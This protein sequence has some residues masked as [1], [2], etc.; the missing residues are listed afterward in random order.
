MRGAAMLRMIR[1]RVAVGAMLIGLLLSGCIFHGG[2]AVNSASAVVRTSIMPASVPYY[3]DPCGQEETEA[4]YRLYPPAALARWLDGKEKSEAETAPEADLRSKH[5]TCAARKRIDNGDPITVR[6]NRVGI[7]GLAKFERTGRGKCLKGCERDIAVVLDFNGGSEIR[8]PIVAF[9][10]T[11][12]QPDGNLQFTNQ[13]IFTQDEWF[14][15]YPPNIR[16]RLYDVRDDRD[17]SLRANLETV[18]RGVNVVTAYIGGA[19]TAGPIVDTAFKAADQLL[20][21]PRN[22]AILDMSFQLFPQASDGGLKAGDPGRP[23]CEV[24][25]GDRDVTGTVLTTEQV[26]AQQSQCQKDKN[27]IASQLNDKKAN[28]KRF[29]TENKLNPSR[30]NEGI[31]GP[32]TKTRIREVVGIGPFDEILKRFY[33]Q[34]DLKEYQNSVVKA[35]DATFE[36]PIYASQYVVFNENAYGLRQITGGPPTPQMPTN[37]E[38][39]SADG[40]SDR[41]IDDR[42]RLIGQRLPVYYFV[43][44]GIN[45]YGARIYS[46]YDKESTKARCVLESPYVLFTISRES[47]AVALDVAA[48]ISALDKRFSATPAISEDTLTTLASTLVDA[49]LSLAIDRL[50]NRRRA[51]DFVKM[52]QTLRDQLARAK[53]T[54]TAPEDASEATK[55][56]T[57]DDAEH[58]K[59]GARYRDRVYRLIEDY[60]ACVVTDD[61][62]DRLGPLIYYWAKHPETKRKDAD[63]TKPYFAKGCTPIDPV[64]AAADAAVPATLPP[65]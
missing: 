54:A 45:Y 40:T 27:K 37:P 19:A 30:S 6:L 15:R 17:K 53:A 21:K 42:R 46:S 48:R 9:Y 25:S 43:P 28:I 47:T 4:R 5:L 51:V 59:P 63:N 60:T 38:S 44:D 62:A 35:V 1:L 55:V 50:E 58:P 23:A 65:Q 13:T 56:A 33:L 20:S 26:T 7:G 31:L 32:Q 39:C 64:T 34:R 12:V 10:Q 41:T 3:V 16:I 2:E 14:F 61:T 49:Q 57:K 29:Q 22:R 8:N 11:G 24:N 36:T 18:K 52:L